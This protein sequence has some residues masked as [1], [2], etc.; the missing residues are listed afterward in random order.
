MYLHIDGKEILLDTLY[1]GC[2]IGGYGSLSDHKQNFSAKIKYS[3][4]ILVLTTEKLH[5]FGS[6]NNQEL[7]ASIKSMKE[8][9]EI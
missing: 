7:Q 5:K 2:S 6:K 1:L 8:S 3:S 4:Q 9:I